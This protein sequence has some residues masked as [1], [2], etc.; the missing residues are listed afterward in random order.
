MKR[1]SKRLASRSDSIIKERCEHNGRLGSALA[2]FFYCKFSFDICF[3]VLFF[4]VVGLSSILGSFLVNFFEEGW[5]GFLQS[6]CYLAAHPSRPCQEGKEVLLDGVRNNREE[7]ERERERQR[8]R[9]EGL[10]HSPR[11]WRIVS[12]RAHQVKHRDEGIKMVRCAVG[13]VEFV[14]L[15]VCLFVFFFTFG[16]VHG[17]AF[18]D[19]ALPRTDAVGSDAESFARLG[20]G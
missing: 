10:S 3:Y 18:A 9:K 20:S 2:A 8:E 4:F 17:R 16:D 14:C 5:L 1:K 13:S 6:L 11:G 12:R 15:F 19:A 7:K